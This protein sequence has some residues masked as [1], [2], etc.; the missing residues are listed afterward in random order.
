MLT[1][2]SKNNPLEW[3]REWVVYVA[4][5]GID[6]VLIYDNGATRYEPEELLRTLAAVGG[7]QRACVVDWPFPYCPGGGPANRWDSDFC[8]YGFPSTRVNASSGE[9][10]K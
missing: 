10:P 2:L 5:H 6:A 1:T 3:L 8:Q 4:E 9:P 7:M